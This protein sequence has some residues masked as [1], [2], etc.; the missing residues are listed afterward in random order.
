MVSCSCSVSQ[1]ILDF[2]LLFFLSCVNYTKVCMRR[3]SDEEDFD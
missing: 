1:H 2:L 3:R